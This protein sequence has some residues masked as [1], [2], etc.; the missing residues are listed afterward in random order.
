M[1]IKKS[2]SK[3]IL[4]DLLPCPHCGSSNLDGPHLNDYVGDTYWPH[5]WI[6]CNECPASMEVNGEDSLLIIN[7]W[8]K[9]SK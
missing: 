5:W 2:K 3:P 4:P 7:A 1:R 9:R 8:N 6:V